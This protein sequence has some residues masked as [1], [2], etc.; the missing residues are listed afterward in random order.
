MLRLNYNQ[1]KGRVWTVGS[2]GRVESTWSGVT[3]VSPFKGMKKVNLSI[4][5]LLTLA[6]GTD[7]EVP[8]I[9]G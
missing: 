7:N 8:P 3:I 6:V 5:V 9:G 4:S 2:V 1:G